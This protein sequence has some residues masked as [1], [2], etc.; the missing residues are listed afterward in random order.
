MDQQIAPTPAQPRSPMLEAID[1]AS[2]AW[3]TAMLD[4]SQ[5]SP[6]AKETRALQAVAE[7]VAT[8][9]IRE[10]ARVYALR[11]AQRVQVAALTERVSACRRVLRS[12]SS[13]D[14]GHALARAALV[15]LHDP[16]DGDPI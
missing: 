3:R 8:P 6:R 9:L 16:Q 14:P 11:R 2:A 13:A 10:L 12:V 4:R 5:R 7:A 15:E 1:R